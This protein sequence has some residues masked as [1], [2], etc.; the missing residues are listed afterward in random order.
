MSPD[1]LVADWSLPNLYYRPTLVQFNNVKVDSINTLQVMHLSQPV[2]IYKRWLTKIEIFYLVCDGLAPLW[3]S[4]PR[5]SPRLPNQYQNWFFWNPGIR[6]ISDELETDIHSI[7]RRGGMQ[8]ASQ[9]GGPEKQQKN[10]KTPTGIRIPKQLPFEYRTQGRQF[11][12]N[13]S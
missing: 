10:S 7:P 4:S 2:Q 3:W 5:E 13:C 9:K 8:L 11:L 1:V 12:R 6:E